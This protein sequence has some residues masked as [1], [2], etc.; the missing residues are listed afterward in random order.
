[1]AENARD[2][3]GEESAQCERRR[4]ALV[5]I[6]EHRADPILERVVTDTVRATEFAGLGQTVAT[7]YAAI[8]RGS[9]PVWLGALGAADRERAQI[10]DENTHYVRELIGHGIPKFVQRALVAFGFRLAN[11]MARDAAQGH[12]FEP[13]ELE[14]ELRVFQRA[15]EARLFYGA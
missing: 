5:T 8:A 13:D 12:G 6:L 14:D 7:R 3:D 10:F 2:I 11:G 9:L 4:T 1:M 15:F